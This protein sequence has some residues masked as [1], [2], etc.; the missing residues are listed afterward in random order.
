VIPISGMV[1]RP[2]L[3]LNGEAPEADRI[4]STR[5]R[6]ARNLAGIHFVG[7]ALEDDLARVYQSVTSAALQAD[8]FRGGAAQAVAELSVLDRQFLLERH[9]ISHDLTGDSGGR[10]LIASSDERASILVNEEDHVR[11]QALE[12]GFQL[13]EAWARAAQVDE[14]LEARL[15]FAWNDELGYLTACPT[16]VGTGMRASVLMHLP[17]LVLTQKMKKILAGVSQ[18][19]LTVRGYYGEGTEVM[20]NFFQISN[21]VTLGE[22][23]QETLTKLTRVVRQILEWEEKASQMLIRQ[24]RWQVE[25]KILRA[26][27]V[28]R[29]C[30]LL[31]SQE[32]IGL[33]SAVRFGVSLG[34]R[35]VP[36][37]GVLNILL[38][39]CQPA[40]LQKT[41]G[42][43]MSSE[44]RNE[45]RAGMVRQV[46][47]VTDAPVLDR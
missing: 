19:G 20:G 7:R 8:E 46:L 45:F 28:L 44:E 9:L 27:G 38:I 35:N 40:H 4:L 26:L 41:A 32:T 30:R 33:L 15:S 34:M 36:A 6:L 29:C 37:V 5:V 11:I 24:A 47:G 22:S 25:D 14:A 1:E 31:S 12:G 42:R 17:G 39:R 13:E 10:G 43:E 18:V 2:G 16:N 3:W 23:E 21:Q